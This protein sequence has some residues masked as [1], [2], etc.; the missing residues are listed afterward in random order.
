MGIGM[1]DALGIDESRTEKAITWGHDISSPMVPNGYWTDER[2]RMICKENNT[3][4]DHAK[5][6][7][8]YLDFEKENADFGQ[9]KK[10]TTEHI[11]FQPQAT[12]RKEALKKQ[13]LIN[14]ISS[15]LPSATV[16]TSRPSRQFY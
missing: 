3:T 10:E 11:F 12:K 5:S 7:P 4:K 1:M 6:N 15:R 8:K 2:I 13:S 9:A 14:P 16:R